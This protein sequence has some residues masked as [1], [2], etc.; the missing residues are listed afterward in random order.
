MCILKGEK[1]QL[2][3]TSSARPDRITV[4]DLT[5]GAQGE[6]QWDSG[7]D[8]TDWPAA[9][10]L[11]ADGNYALQMPDRPRRQVTIKVLDSKPADADLLVEL[12]RLGCRAQ[13]EAWLRQAVTPKS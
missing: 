2:V 9:V 3:R 13:F 6:A 1:L 10:Q 8:K 7:S 11:R 5:S 12:H 4:V